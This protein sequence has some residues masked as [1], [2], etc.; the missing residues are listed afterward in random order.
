M[1]GDGVTGAAVAWLGVTALGLVLLVA[2]FGSG[3][4]NKAGLIVFGALLLSMGASGLLGLVRDPYSTGIGFGLLGLLVPGYS[5][6]FLIYYAA[7]ASGERRASRE[8]DARWAA[9]ES[10]KREA[11]LICAHC[12]LLDRGIHKNWCPDFG[13]EVE[14][15]VHEHGEWLMTDGHYVPAGVHY[16]VR[17][18]CG[19]E[20]YRCSTREA[21]VEQFRFFH[22]DSPDLKIVP[23][24]RAQ[25]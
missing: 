18:S 8:Q 2:G 19:T 16:S 14:M 22:K 12:G 25:V 20:T 24:V 11:G 7:K 4:N 17:C 3:P 13:H 5:L 21:A 1:S 6:P 15:V 10:A 9:E 23:E